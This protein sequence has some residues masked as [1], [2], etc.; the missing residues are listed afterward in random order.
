[1]G[2]S[3]I[4]VI[5]VDL[6]DIFAVCDWHSQ[7]LEPNT[8]IPEKKF[9]CNEESPFELLVKH[10]STKAI[11]CFKNKLIH[12][13]DLLYNYAAA[14]TGEAWWPA[15]VLVRLEKKCVSILTAKESI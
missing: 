11:N 9:P 3:G 1:M 5:L 12:F 2:Y 7:K 13:G 6:A 10:D 4:L 15:R 8:V 14:W